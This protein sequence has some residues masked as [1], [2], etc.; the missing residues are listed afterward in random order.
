MNL[1]GL[2]LGSDPSGGVAEEPLG[3]LEQPGHVDAAMDDAVPEWPPLEI[4]DGVV[5]EWPP[6]PQPEHRH[7][8]TMVTGG[9]ACACGER[10]P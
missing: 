9:M 3:R 8:F 4:I 6:G 7:I 10:I 5:T 1:L 2:Q